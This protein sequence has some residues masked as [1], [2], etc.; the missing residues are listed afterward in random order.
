MYGVAAC[1]NLH[2][3]QEKNLP[4]AVLQ[5]THEYWQLIPSGWAIL[6]GPWYYKTANNILQNFN[7]V[8][9]EIVSQWAPSISNISNDFKRIWTILNEL[10]WT[11]INKD[12]QRHRETERQKKPKNIEKERQK[13]RKGW[14]DGGA[15]GVGV[16]ITNFWSIV[17]DDHWSKKIYRTKMIVW[18]PVLYSSQMILFACKM[19]YVFQ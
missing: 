10:R 16:V 3:F 15:R 13:D 12:K 18:W 6:D 14:G 2:A 19:L 8:I 11:N 4:S 1:R 17:E 9:I 5:W 7:L